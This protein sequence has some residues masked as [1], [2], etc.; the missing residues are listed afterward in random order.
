[1][2]REETAKDRMNAEDSEL[3]QQRMHKFRGTGLWTSCT[4]LTNKKL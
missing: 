1:M 2:W 4:R 3:G